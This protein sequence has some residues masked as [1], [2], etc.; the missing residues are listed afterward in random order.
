VPSRRRLIAQQKSA[1]RFSLYLRQNLLH[2]TRY[3]VA[4]MK[5]SLLLWSLTTLLAIPSFAAPRQAPEKPADKLSIPTAP[6]EKPAPVEEMKV[7]DGADY[8]TFNGMKVPPMKEINGEEF[9]AV[10]KEGYWYDPARTS[11]I[12]TDTF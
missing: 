10:V 11:L 1:A 8:T 5:S 2:P 7:D 3:P 4:T 12:A 6:A 9:D